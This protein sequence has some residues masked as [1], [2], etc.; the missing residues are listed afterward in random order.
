MQRQSEYEGVNRE[1]VEVRE[2][3]MAVSLRR[4]RGRIYFVEWF[5][6]FRAYQHHLVRPYFALRMHA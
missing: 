5:R 4:A 1:T 2:G 6:R 3:E